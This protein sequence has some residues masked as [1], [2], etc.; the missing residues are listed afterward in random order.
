MS[1]TYVLKVTKWVSREEQ[2]ELT[3]AIL[4]YHGK[5][6]NSVLSHGLLKF[7]MLFVLLGSK[8]VSLKIDMK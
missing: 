8:R 6:P 7:L 4:I 3:E 5:N 2:P 1:D